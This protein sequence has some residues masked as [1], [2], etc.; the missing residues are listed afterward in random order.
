MSVEIKLD[1]I[2]HKK[3]NKRFKLMEKHYPEETFVAITKILLDIKF[4]AQKKIKSNGNIVTSRLRNSIF[5]KTKGQKHVKTATNKISYTYEGGSGNRQL[6]VMVG[7]HE[8]AVGTNVEYA[9]AIENGSKPHT[10]TAKTSKGLRFKI[11]GQWITK[12]SVHHPGYKGK[13]FLGYATKTVNVNKRFQEI[14]KRANK[15]IK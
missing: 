11:N 8:G 3:L 14:P 13:S 9:D 12:Q 5:V 2:S 10:I 1:P 15:K 6:S 7:K 4:I